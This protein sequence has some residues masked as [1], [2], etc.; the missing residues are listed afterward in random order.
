MIQRSIASIA[1]AA[2]A[3]LLLQGP[4]V[5]AAEAGAAG[6]R[7]QVDGSAFGKLAGEDSDLVEI[8]LGPTLLGAIARG[9]KDDPEAALLLAGL[10][11]V[12][13]YIV[14]LEGDPER[15]GKA[16]KLM[17]DMEGRLQREGW[18]RLAHVREKGERVNVF[19][20]GGDGTVEG[21]VVLVLER[22]EGQ[23]VF[24]NIA[25]TLDLA[26][27]DDIGDALDLDVP[28]LDGLGG[29]GRPAGEAR[30]EPKSPAGSSQPDRHHEELP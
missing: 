27:L 11:S 25:G 21:L 19:V 13:A 12:T 17:Q 2:C 24:V 4:A 9:A 5:L 23:V 29:A 26:K 3:L 20:L 6:V 10:R 30:G 28:G 18:E 16:A 14:G 8:H 15:T 1:L 22:D 7:G